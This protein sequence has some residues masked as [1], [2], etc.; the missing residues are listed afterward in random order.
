MAARDPERAAPTR[1]TGEA[2]RGDQRVEEREPQRGEDR[3]GPQVRLDPFH[4]R[5]QREQL[6]RR[7]QIEQLVDQIRR[8]IDRG[9]PLTRPGP[10]R[11]AVGILRRALEIFEIEGSVARLRP[12][13][14]IAADRAPIGPLD[15]LWR[16][17]AITRPRELVGDEHP[18]AGRA[19]CREEI[20]HR[21]LEARLA[22]WRRRHPLERCVEVAHVRRAEDDLRQHPGQRARFD[23]DRAALTVDRGTRH[24]AASTGQIRDDVSG[25]RVRLDARR[26]QERRRRR[27]QPLEDR[28]VAA[29][30]GAGG[31]VPD[32]HLANATSLV[33]ALRRGT[34]DRDVPASRAYASSSSSCSSSKASSVV[35]SGGSTRSRSSISSSSSSSSRSSSSSIS[36]RTSVPFV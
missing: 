7:V 17:L 1:A 18:A 12:T 30:V 8:A 13:A 16:R 36:S 5:G 10:R 14:H 28:E 11:A 25:S 9:E 33:P 31:V 24:P 6:A 32:G 35:A 15:R 26:K 4:D 27:R 21:D 20:T 2:A 34:R 3:R 29:H 23:R 22:A 19:P